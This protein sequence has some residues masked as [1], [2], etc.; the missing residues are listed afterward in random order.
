[1]NG[2]RL[3]KVLQ[4]FFDLSVGKSRNRNCAGEKL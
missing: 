3:H 2:K 1:M 4:I